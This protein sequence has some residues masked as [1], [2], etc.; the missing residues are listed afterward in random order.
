MRAALRVN[1]AEE[2]GKVHGG[3]FPYHSHP[4][5]IWAGADFEAGEGAKA[6]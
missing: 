3:A 6:V 1:L 5:R 2:P 4:V